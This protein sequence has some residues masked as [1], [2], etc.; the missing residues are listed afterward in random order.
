[1]KL[2][3]MGETG[4]DL[5]RPSFVACGVHLACS[6]TTSLENPLISKYF[7]VRQKWGVSCVFLSNHVDIDVQYW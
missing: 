6:G 5:R 4:R 3:L 1:M 2:H 7:V